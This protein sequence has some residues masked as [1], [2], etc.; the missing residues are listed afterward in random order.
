MT[1]NMINKTPTTAKTAA[2]IK[3]FG[4]PLFLSLEKEKKSEWFHL[5]HKM[6][7][8]VFTVTNSHLLIWYT[9]THAQQS[10]FKC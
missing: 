9:T 1:K 8:F 2:K 5:L 3:A 4:T 6:I 10:D 7:K